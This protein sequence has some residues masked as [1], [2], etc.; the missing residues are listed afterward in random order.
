MGLTPRERVLRAVDH[1][2][3]DRVPLDLGGTYTSSISR[4]AYEKLLAHLNLSG[5]SHIIRKW[6]SVVKPDEAL[7]K[8]FDVDT[9]MVVPRFED[10]W[11][12]YWKLTPVGEE[13]AY[14]DEWGVVWRKPET[15]HAFISS[16][17]LSGRVDVG[18]L[19]SFSW[20]DPDDPARY[21]GLKEQARELKENTD[22][23][24]IG[25]FP[26]PIVS[27]SQ[28]L[29]GYE[30]WFMDMGMNQAFLE[31]LM[32]YILET[33]LKIGKRMLDDIGKYVDLMFVHDDLATQESLMFSPDS[34]R[35]IVKPRHQKIFNLIKTHSDAKIIYHTDGSVFPLLEDFVEIGVDALNPVQ[36]SAQGM[37]SEKLNR[38]F[39][40]RLCFW[41]GIDTQHV[42]PAGSPE[43]VREEVRRQIEWLGK[44]G[45]YVLSAVH[46]IQ[47]DVSPDNIVAMFA[48]A[49]EYGSYS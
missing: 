32:D 46:N 29:R 25:V 22:Y 5:R 6:A 42:L 15:G 7:L 17:P 35:S 36:T 18:A 20:P 4:G 13:D 45:N 43:D 34:Y 11:N 47:D 3:P 30:D 14:R 21:H 40:D 1:K 12:E 19:A 16:H 37:D 39:G 27:L 44:D 24:V 9:R 31:V 38:E 8:H 49:R 10:T 33:D 26:R 2:E 48:A 28:F 23:A 41:G